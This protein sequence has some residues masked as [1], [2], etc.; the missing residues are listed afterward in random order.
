MDK[1]VKKASWQLS[2]HQLAWE[3]GFNS[4]CLFCFNETR[5]DN[6]ITLTGDAY[7]DTIVDS[8][9]V[10]NENEYVTKVMIQIS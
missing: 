4:N 10:Q 1:T 9:A 7:E 8:F 5:M 6:K 3:L 2:L